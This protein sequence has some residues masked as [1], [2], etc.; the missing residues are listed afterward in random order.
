[1]SVFDDAISI[2]KDAGYRLSEIRRPPERALFEDETV[3]GALIAYPD[4]RTLLESWQREQD[5]FLGECAVQIRGAATKAW[6]I[7]TVH[8]TSKFNDNEELNAL[9]KI[10]EDFRATRKIAKVAVSRDE[11][12]QA[13]LP[14]L[15]LQAYA[16]GAVEDLPER[17]RKAL[18]LRPDTIDTILTQS[19]AE[20]AK[21]LLE[22][23]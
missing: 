23:S 14:L 9:S 12:I 19:P 8:L 6:N 10:E 7:Y 15:P 11:A 13:L 16:N 20:I 21:K 17:L 4:A 1:M 2:L 22:E 3:M 5:R 18:K